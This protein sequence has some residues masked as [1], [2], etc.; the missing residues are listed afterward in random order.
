MA[1]EGIPHMSGTWHYESGNIN[2]RWYMSNAPDVTAEFN[3]TQQPPPELSP[4][5]LCDYCRGIF[6]STERHLTCW[7]C[8]TVC[9]TK[10]HTPVASNG[11]NFIC[12]SCRGVQR[13]YPHCPPVRR[14]WC[15]YFKMKTLD[16]KSNKTADNL[17]LRLDFARPVD[18]PKAIGLCQGEGSNMYGEFSVSG[19]LYAKPTSTSASLYDIRF[20]KRY[21]PVAGMVH[22]PVAVRSSSPPSPTFKAATSPAL[23]TTTTAVSPPLPAPP[24]PTLQRTVKLNNL[25]RLDDETHAGKKRKMSFKS[26]DSVSP[27]TTASAPTAVTGT[28]SQLPALPASVALPPRPPVLT[29]VSF[30]EAGEPALPVWVLNHF[31]PVRDWERLF[32]LPSPSYCLPVG[33]IMTVV[34]NV[35]LLGDVNARAAVSAACHAVEAVADS[36]QSLAISLVPCGTRYNVELICSAFASPKWQ[37]KSIGVFQLLSNTTPPSLHVNSANS[38]PRVYSS[39]LVDNKVNRDSVLK[40][41]SSLHMCNILLFSIQ[42]NAEDSVTMVSE[43]VL[44][45]KKPTVVLVQDLSETNASL[46]RRL[47]A[48]MQESMMQSRLLGWPGATTTVLDVKLPL[49]QPASV[50]VATGPKR[51]TSMPNPPSSSV[52]AAAP[53]SNLASS[54]NAPLFAPTSYPQ[55]PQP[56]AQHAGKSQQ[57]AAAPLPSPEFPTPQPQLPR[58][59]SLPQQ[60]LPHTLPSSPLPQPVSGNSLPQPKPPSSSATTSSSSSSSSLPQPRSFPYAPALPQPANSLP[61]PAPA[62]PQPNKSA[63]PPRPSAVPP[64]QTL[65]RP[66]G[67]APPPQQ[68]AAVHRPTL[69]VLPPASVAVPKPASSLPQPNAYSSSSSL[70]HPL[71]KPQPQPPFAP[72][73]SK[74]PRGLEFEVPPIIDATTSAVAAVPLPLPRAS[75]VVVD[76][77]PLPNGSTTASPPHVA[78]AAAAT[79]VAAPPPPTIKRESNGW[80][81]DEEEESTDYSYLL[82]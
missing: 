31:R 25:A 62:L 58:T 57:V 4:N 32:C 5:A 20:T 70:H 42:T 2:G 27:P 1:E 13:Q 17:N 16:G 14:S 66:T 52:A 11:G 19:Y 63:V 41:L 77:S 76:D 7:S 36:K 54:N 72:F 56:Q 44:A 65:P 51:Y 39:Q 80:D 35:D 46:V 6:T 67:A 43:A 68:P 73:A 71:P 50:T 82:T 23:A 33:S 45:L 78:A 8:F 60:R 29:V 28:V 53:T 12:Q 47:V 64:P 37:D 49:P 22:Q 38:L 30:L 26:L 74:R 21:L 15:G 59:A 24:V 10:C 69:T 61:Q 55:Q 3:Y 81:D 9:H 34:G 75:I 40:A 18:D 79:V 48:K